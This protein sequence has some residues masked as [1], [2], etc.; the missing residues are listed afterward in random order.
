MMKNALYSMLNAL[1]FFLRYS[2][3]CLTFQLCRK[4]V[5]AFHGPRPFA[6]PPVPAPTLDPNLYLPA[7]AP[8]LYLPALAL[9]CIYQ[10]LPPIC[11]YWSWPLI[12]IYKPWLPICIYRSWPTILLPVRSLSLHIPTLSPQ[13]VFAF[14]ALAYNLYYQ[15]RSYLIV[16]TSSSGSSNSSSSCFFGINNTNICMSIL[17]NQGNKLKCVRT[18]AA[19]QIQCRIKYVPSLYKKQ[20]VA[21]KLPE[22]DLGLL[23]HPRQS[24]L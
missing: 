2:Y 3:F 1:V 6:W 10:S 17:V 15:S 8:N 4:R 18:Q 12:C 13:F 11:I 16:G 22:A 21:C 23:Q 24:T 9:I 7:L 19:T 5:F 20:E 14:T